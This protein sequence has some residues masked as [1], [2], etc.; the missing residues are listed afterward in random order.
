VFAVVQC[1][2]AIDW[3][4]LSH[5]GNG[6]QVFTTC[7]LLKTRHPVLRIQATRYPCLLDFHS[8][9]SGVYDSDFQWRANISGRIPLHYA[10]ARRINLHHAVWTCRCHNG[11]ATGPHDFDRCAGHKGE[12][13]PGGFKPATAYTGHDEVAVRRRQRGRQTS[14][15]ACGNGSDGNRI[16]SYRGTRRCRHADAAAR[17]TGRSGAGAARSTAWFA[18]I[19]ATA[20]CGTTAGDTAT[21]P[22]RCST[23]TGSRVGARSGALSLTLSL[24]LSLAWAVSLT[25]PLTWALSLPLTLTLS[26]TLSLAVTAGISAH[27]LHQEQE[28]MRGGG[29]LRSIET[30]DV[31]GFGRKE[32]AS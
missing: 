6:S 20:L 24:T 2:A 19:A 25:L 8:P 27:A 32:W 26:L 10:D 29:A 11:L 17:L 1:N 3:L 5:G 14:V 23:A 12:A 15:S 18:G 4:V 30:E 21:G 22:A 13:A 16:G 28:A 7:R 9:L 31:E